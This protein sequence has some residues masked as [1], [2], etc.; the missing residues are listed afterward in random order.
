MR[1]VELD[2]RNQVQYAPAGIRGALMA[3]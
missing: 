1:Q 3:L 2:H